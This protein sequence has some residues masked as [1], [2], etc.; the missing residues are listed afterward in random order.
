MKNGRKN[1]EN[2]I[3]KKPP[4]SIKKQKGKPD[5]RTQFSS[6]RRYAEK[7]LYNMTF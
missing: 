1:T 6:S 5:D 4:N 2:S 3:N 7:K